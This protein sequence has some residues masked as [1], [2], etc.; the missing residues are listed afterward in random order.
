[1]TALTRFLYPVPASRSAGAIVRWWESRRLAY[2]LLVG[3]AGLVSVFSLN[4]AA[5]LF[6]ESPALPWEPIVVFGLGANV[7]YT[8]GWILESGAHAAW[9]REVMPFGPALFRTGLVFSVGLALLPALVAP[10]FVA[11]AVVRLLLGLG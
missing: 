3:A 4:V 11:V 10:L 2:N 1:M 6:G 5:V 9:G 7:Y 8:L